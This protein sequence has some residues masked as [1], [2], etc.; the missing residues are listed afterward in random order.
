MTP[1]LKEQIPSKVDPCIEGRQ[2]K[3]GRVASHESVP[4][5]IKTVIVQMFTLY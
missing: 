5:H 2:K 1:I 3:N 4:M